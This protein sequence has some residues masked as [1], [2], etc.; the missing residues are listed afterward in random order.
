MRAPSHTETQFSTPLGES[1]WL[2]AQ[3]VTKPQSSAFPD[4]ERWIKLAKWNTCM[5]KW[6][7]FLSNCICVYLNLHTTTV[8]ET[9]SNPKCVGGTILTGFSLISPCEHSLV[10]SCWSPFHGRSC[11][12]NSRIKI[13]WLK[14]ITFC[15]WTLNLCPS[16]VTL[17][18]M[19]GFRHW[20]PLTSSVV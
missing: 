12:W 13:K 20:Y 7:E 4:S 6:W 10:S 5:C 17:V 2:G 3:C 19:F 9:C 8:W 1:P 11:H 14:M 16:C 15:L 18:G